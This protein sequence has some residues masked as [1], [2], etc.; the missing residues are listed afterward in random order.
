M[1]V[2]LKWLET[3]N[4][5]QVNRKPP[6]AS[7]K[8]SMREQPPSES[9]VLNS[10]DVSDFDDVLVPAHFQTQ[11]YGKNQYT[12]TAYPWDGQEEVPY[13]KVWSRNPHMR[14]VLNL[15]RGGG[16]RF[17][18]RGKRLLRVA[19]RGICRLFDGFV[20]TVRF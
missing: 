9:F 5:T 12:N 10:T 15:Q 4:V 16:T 19:E 8:R 1:N 14:Y 13:G 11:G 6:H 7:L 3:P 20:Y 18:W 2:S 17:S